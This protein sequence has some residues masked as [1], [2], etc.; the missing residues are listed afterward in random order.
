MIISPPYAGSPN[1]SHQLDCV[2]GVV[3]GGADVDIVA[4]VV[5]FKEVVVAVVV[6]QEGSTMAIN[7][8]SPIV[9]P[10]MYFFIDSSFF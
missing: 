3:A 6:V 10:M 4:V 9:A 2:A 5:G 7:N 8:R 1:L